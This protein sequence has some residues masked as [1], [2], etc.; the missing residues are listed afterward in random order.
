MKWFQIVLSGLLGTLANAA[1]AQTGNDL[2][3]LCVSKNQVERMAC[4]L[5]VAGFVQAMQLA[6]GL[7]GEVCIP[8]KL[9]GAEATEVFIRTL[10]EIESAGAKGKGVPRQANPF[11]T[12]EQSSALA[13]SLGLR[14]PCASKN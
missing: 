4:E 14:F 3:S 2:F 9:T 1:D 8:E 11:F 7:Q 10:R 6:P 5:Y 13:A 12:E